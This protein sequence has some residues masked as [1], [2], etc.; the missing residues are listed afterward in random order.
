MN[1][2]FHKKVNYKVKI[3][4]FVNL[5]NKKRTTNTEK[6][7]NKT[8]LNKFMLQLIKD[9]TTTLIRNNR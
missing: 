6:S 8:R 7:K 4:I 1:K 9:I 3:F 2:E 5:E